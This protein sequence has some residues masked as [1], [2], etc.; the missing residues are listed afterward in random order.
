M[1][2]S[3]KCLKFSDMRMLLRDH[4]SETEIANVSKYVD[5][6]MLALVDDDGI[7]YEPAKPGTINID[8]LLDSLSANSPGHAS[9]RL[10]VEEEASVA[11]EGLK[12]ELNRLKREK[13]DDNDFL[14]SKI[15]QLKRQVQQAISEKEEA[16]EYSKQVEAQK[17]RLEKFLKQGIHKGNTAEDLAQDVSFVTRRLEL[18]E[19]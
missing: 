1:K 5:E 3:G 6:K 18:L 12:R 8:T 15:R 4:L 7:A 17:C 10:A 2:Y 13:E 9:D 14:N 11:Y 19:S 16:N